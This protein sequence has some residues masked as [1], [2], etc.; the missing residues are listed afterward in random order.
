MSG[1]LLYSKIL[2][3]DDEPAAVEV[4]EDFL[5]GEQF[6]VET[7][8]DGESAIAK[9]EDFRPHCVLLDVRMPYLGGVEALK[10]IKLRNPETEVIMVTA[11]SS[12]KMAEECMRSGAYGYITK[13]VDLDLL[14][15]EVRDALEH[16]K[17]VIDAKRKEEQAKSGIKEKNGE[18]ETEGQVKEKPEEKPSENHKATLKTLSS[19]LNEELFNALKFPL[20]LIGYSLPEFSCHSRNVSE[21]SRKIAQQLKLSHI[22]LVELAGLYH[23]IGKLCL[24]SQLQGKS[25]NEWTAQERKIY[26]KF[27]E[28]GSD[29]VQTHFHLKG[30]ASVIYHQ[31]ENMDGSGFPDHLEGDHIPIEARVIAVANALVEAKSEIAPGNIRLDYEKD[32]G[33]LANLQAYSGTRYDP[34]VLQALEELMKNNKYNH[35]L[36]IEKDVYDLREGMILSRDLLSG[37][38]KFLFASDTQLNKEEVQRILDLN[39]FDPI[40]D[41]PKIYPS[42]TS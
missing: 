42:K 29:L 17:S 36:D 18:D 41:L 1:P 14:N 37:S 12:V 8:G 4:L 38:G 31:C 27:P 35:T 7:A 2:V 5:T 15:K 33:V 19:V 39:Q 13:P 3:V 10:M 6:V 16:R 20:E 28:Y 34:Q 32:Q 30:L 40:I 22:R 11:F 9:L 24:P 25:S 23:D 26:E 21:V